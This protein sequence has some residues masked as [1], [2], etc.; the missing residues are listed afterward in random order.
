M[1]TLGHRS[2]KRNTKKR[3]Q[4][5]QLSAK[6]TQ[7][8]GGISLA[9]AV[10]LAGAAVYGISAG[11]GGTFGLQKP[12]STAAVA[13]PSK[14]ESTLPLAPH[15]VRLLVLGDSLAHGF[16]DQSGR[17]FAGDVAA[18]YRRQGNTV[19]YENLG[20]DGLTSGQLW[21]QLQ[22]PSVQHEV[23][24]AS[25]VLISI[26]GNDL[27]N[28]AGLPHIKLTR[29][30]RAETV[31]L[32]NLTHI[33]TLTRHLNHTSPVILVGLYNPYANV[34]ASAR[35]TNAIVEAWNAKEEAVVSTFS[36]MTVVP[37]MDLFAFHLNRYLYVDHF[38][39]N[40]LGYQRIAARIWQ[41]LK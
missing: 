34:S 37:T 15:S 12:S 20:I 39:P 13:S 5:G 22:Q 24:N 18:D 11:E 31:F 8:A 30:H 17:G 1:D 26:G 32:T 33:L 29:I 4:R 3:K 19:I 6:A 25:V 40:E 14:P 9:A 38:H 23:K 28:S 41:D 21:A 16:G 7:I 27:H 35:Q 36:R 10:V 2:D